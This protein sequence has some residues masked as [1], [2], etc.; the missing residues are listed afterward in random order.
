MIRITAL[1]AITAAMSLA[2]CQPQKTPEQIAAEQQAAALKAMTDSLGGMAGPNGEVDAEK[3]AAAIGQASAM[4]RLN[5]DITPEERAKLEAIGHAISTG[6][7]HP[8]ASA[9]LAGADKAV[10]LLKT[11]KDQASLNAVKPQLAAIYAEMAA[12]AATL[13]AMTEDQREVAF[14]S[15]APQ[16]ISLSTRMVG[17]LSGTSYDP[18]TMQALGELLDQMPQT[19]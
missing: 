14:G 5:P 3:L 10:A 8:A 11:A 18:Q 13:K 7:V 6:E 9:Y 17:L 12:P 4:A 19:E 16:W 15:A 2:A 1:V